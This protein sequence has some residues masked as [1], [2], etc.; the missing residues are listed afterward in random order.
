MCRS[1]GTKRG[2]IQQRERERERAITDPV[3]E[4]ISSRER[5]RVITDPVKKKNDVF[6]FFISSFQNLISCEILWLNQ[7]KK[8]YM[9][10]ID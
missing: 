9:P 7:D 2:D 5:E 6:T 1:F 10:K 4:V 3:K 8:N